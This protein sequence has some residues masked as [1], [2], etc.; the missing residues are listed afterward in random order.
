[1]LA[2]NISIYFAISLT[3]IAAYSILIVRYAQI[4][5]L[6]M[7]LRLLRIFWRVAGPLGALATLSYPEPWVTCAFCLI[8]IAA[9]L[10]GT[11]YYVWL[12]ALSTQRLYGTGQTLTYENVRHRLSTTIEMWPKTFMKVARRRGR[13]WKQIERTLLRG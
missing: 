1:M 10:G 11:R 5:N 3:M 9:F 4:E 13:D 2:I 6:L 8:V 12:I 7:N